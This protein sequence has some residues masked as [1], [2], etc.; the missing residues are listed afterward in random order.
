MVRLVSLLL[1]IGLFVCPEF[2]PAQ[3]L[4]LFGGKNHE[5]FLGC[6]NC[7]KYDSGSIWNKYGEYG[8]KYSD[9]SIWNKYGTFGS[10]YN[11][12]SPWNKYSNDPPII[13]DKDGN[14]YGYF[15]AN[16][17]FHNRTK[18]KS[19]VYILDNYEEVIERLDKIRDDMK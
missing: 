4:L 19:L 16:K 2:L 11:S 12:Y 18:D 14:N 15:T 8:S 9:K 13:V 5:T 6:L 10:K 17:Y 1:S 3:T 7:S